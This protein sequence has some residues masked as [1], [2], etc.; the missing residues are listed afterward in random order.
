MA[1]DRVTWGAKWFRRFYR[2][3]SSSKVH[4]DFAAIKK[5]R[6]WLLTPLAIWPVN[7]DIIGHHALDQIACGKP[8]CR[9]ID[10][11]IRLLSDPP[12][13]AIQSLITQ[14]EHEI[15]KGDYDHL[16]R[17]TYKFSLKEED[18]K[19]NTR[20]R[21]EWSEIEKIF[22][23]KQFKTENPF[24]WRFFRQHHEEYAWW[25]LNWN[26][27]EDRFRAVFNTFCYRWHLS[28]MNGN[29]PL[30]L[31]TNI[32]LTP[33]GT[34][35]FIPFYWSLDPHRDIKWAAVSTLHRLRGIG[36]QGPKLYQ[37]RWERKEMGRRVKLLL[38]KA[39]EK[40]FRGEDRDYWVMGQ[41][42]WNIGTDP[43]QVRRYVKYAEEKP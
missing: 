20:L 19:Q 31:K 16:V 32:H 34:S 10:L 35:I 15:E 40:G 6:E 43:M 38:A 24:V 29:K 30:L 41:M 36:K 23:V 14:H 8:I 25:N 22:N 11:I 17:A 26:N 27:D 18:L 4:P 28:G 21:A 2:L 12:A 5:L 13:D 7:L 42:G 3:S 1:F 9:E 39:K 33:F 37:E